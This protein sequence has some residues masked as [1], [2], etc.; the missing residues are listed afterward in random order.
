[1]ASRLRVIGGSGS[2]AAA[3]ARNASL[4]CR[5][6]MQ[7]S[8]ASAPPAAAIAPM[9]APDC[10]CKHSRS[11]GGTSGIAGPRAQTA[12][13]RGIEIIGQLMQQGADCL[14]AHRPAHATATAQEAYAKER[15]SQPRCN[16]VARLRSAVP[17]QHERLAPRRVFRRHSLQ[18]CSAARHSTTVHCALALTCLPRDL[19]VVAGE[20]PAPQVQR[21]PAHNCGTTRSAGCAALRRLV[22]LEGRR[23][24]QQLLA[25]SKSTAAV[26]AQRRRCSGAGPLASGLSG[27]GPLLGC[28]LPASAQGCALLQPHASFQYRQ[29]HPG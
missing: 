16:D 26:R 6:R 28:S 7:D 3:A 15:S 14:T 10:C 17:Q 9:M 12:S 4:L 5:L 2:G 29:G 25:G 22:L 27:H 8:T 18:E 21:L 24:A 13:S 20:P 19:T 11:G 1:M 23:R